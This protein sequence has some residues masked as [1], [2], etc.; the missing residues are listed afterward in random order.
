MTQHL[1]KKYISI[2]GFY[3]DIRDNLISID[4]ITINRLKNKNCIKDYFINKD[5]S[6][7]YPDYIFCK[8]VSLLVSKKIFKAKDD[9]YFV[10]IHINNYYH[11]YKLDQIN[12]LIKFLKKINNDTK[13]I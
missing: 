13:S 3:N 7:T 9:Y 10:L 2:I 6:K 8:D 11:A 5:F 12:E 4:S 1:Y